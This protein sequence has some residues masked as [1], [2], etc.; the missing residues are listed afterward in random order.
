M[1]VLRQMR[2]PFGSP[3]NPRW[4]KGQPEKNLH[5]V[6]QKL[7]IKSGP[8]PADGDSPEHIG[9]SVRERCVDQVNGDLATRSLTSNL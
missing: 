6:K 5:N 9:D 8:E 4:K 1:K 2:R 7:T 3:E